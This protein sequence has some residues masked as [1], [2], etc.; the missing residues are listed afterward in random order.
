MASRA[1]NLTVQLDAYAGY[2]K[3]LAE[4]QLGDRLRGKVDPG[5]LVQQTLLKACEHW[6]SYRGKLDRELR[7]WLRAILANVII[8]HV[9]KFVGPDGAD[10]EKSLE[11]DLERSS[12]R[13]ER[14]LQDDGSS[15]SVRASRN[16]R[17]LLLADAL[18][19]LPA[20]QRLVIELRHLQ[21]ESLERIA[22]AIGRSLPAVAGLLRRGLQALRLDLQ[23][24]SGPGREPR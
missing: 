18:S 23:N 24:L 4:A 20:D 9:R 22:A 2:L 10:R 12:L 14:V 1:A 3:I 17:L 7:G 11:G 6:D 5:D 16:E 8:D 15:P 13:L 19:R 21:G